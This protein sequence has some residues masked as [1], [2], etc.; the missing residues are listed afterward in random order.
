VNRCSS[1]VRDICSNVSVTAV[2]DTNKAAR[3]YVQHV[4]K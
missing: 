4:T 1:A 3:R 2:A